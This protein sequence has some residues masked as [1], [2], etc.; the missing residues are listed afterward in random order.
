M[1]DIWPHRL[2]N[3]SKDLLRINLYILLVWFSDLFVRKPRRTPVRL[4]F[5]HMTI[6]NMIQKELAALI[7]VRVTTVN[8]WIRG[9]SMPSMDNLVKLAEVFRISEADFFVGEPK[10]GD[11]RNKYSYMSIQKQDL[12]RLFDKNADFRRYVE[13]GLS[14]ARSGQIAKLLQKVEE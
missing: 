5:R 6:N 1:Q 2:Y 3:I 4:R 9:I 14:A 12:L 13:I 11:T 8:N 10:D 7:G